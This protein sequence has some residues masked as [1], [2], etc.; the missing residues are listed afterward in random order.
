MAI[1]VNTFEFLH[2]QNTWAA[3]TVGTLTKKLYYNYPSAWVSAVTLP[4]W[5]EADPAVAHPYRVHGDAMTTVGKTAQLDLTDIVM[6]STIQDT[7][8]CYIKGIKWSLDTTSVK[9]T[10]ELQK[11]I[12]Y[13]YVPAWLEAIRW[14]GK[15]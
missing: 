4:A 5:H 6:V 10:L 14:K 9:T 2:N 11:P 13:E 12:P 7:Y 1:S 8:P 15:D 3:R